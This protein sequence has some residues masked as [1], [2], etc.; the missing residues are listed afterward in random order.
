MLLD[1]G[2]NPNLMSK[3]GFN[4]MHYACEQGDLTIVKLLM[5]YG[6]DINI[7]DKLGHNCT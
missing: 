6:V 7:R 3:C 2:A 4:A 5:C 1:A